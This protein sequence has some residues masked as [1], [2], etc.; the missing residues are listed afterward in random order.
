MEPWGP[1]EAELLAAHI[2][3]VTASVAEPDEGDIDDDL[4]LE[5]EDEEDMDDAGLTEVL[6]VLDI[7][8]GF[9]DFKIDDR[10]PNWY[11]SD[12]YRTM[13]RLIHLW[14]RALFEPLKGSWADQMVWPAIQGHSLGRP[15]SYGLPMSTGLARSLQWSSHVWWSGQ[16]DQGSNQEDQWQDQ[17]RTMGRPVVGP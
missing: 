13:I 2:D 6:E 7:A 16:V 4:E 8:D 9:Q 12:E 5:P 14:V 10:A 1:T 3:A 11:C 15:L 17:E